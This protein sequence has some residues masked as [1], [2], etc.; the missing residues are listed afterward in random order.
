[1]GP[2]FY[3]KKFVKS[4]LPNLSDDL[5]SSTKL[6][7]GLVKP[8]PKEKEIN[9]SAAYL[10]IVESPSKCEKIESYL[11]SQY[12]CIASKGHIRTID[13]L[14]AIDIKNNFEP[15]FTL[16]E[17]K[18]AHVEWMRTTINR[19]SKN[20]IIIASDDDREGE[21]IAWHICQVFELPIETTQRIIFHEVTKPALLEAVK[22]PTKINMDLV[23]AQHARQVLDIL[24]GYKIS[25]YLWKYIYNSKA[26]SLSAGRCQT[27]AL[28]LVYDN[29]KEKKDGIEMRY[30]TIGTF[31]S[32][33]LPYELNK[34]FET[35]E[36]VLLFLEKSRDYNYKLTIHNP[37]ESIRSAPKPFN[38]SRLLQVSSNVLHISPKETM[39]LCQKLYQSG[40]ITYMRTE[41]SQYSPIFVDKI[42]EY[43]SS[44]PPSI[45]SSKKTREDLGFV[46]PQNLQYGVKYVGNV[47]KIICKD[48]GAPHEA[49]RVTNVEMS[50]L[51]TDEP[52]LASMYKLI[53]KN[54]VESCMADAKYNNIKTNI[55][56]PFELL[57][58]YTIEIPVFLGWQILDKKGSD[59][60]EMTSLHMYLS[61]LSKGTK[62]IMH[63]W[64]ESTIVMKNRHSHYTE[65]SLIHKLEEL[66]IGRPSTFASIVDTI[67]DRGYVKKTDLAGEKMNCEEYKLLDNVVHSSVKERIF[68]NEKNKLV[69]QS[70]GILTIEFLLKTF[71]KMFSYEYT[72]NMELD[73]DLVSSGKEA[74]W[75]KI[76]ANCLKDIK[77]HS[78]EIRDLTKQTYKIDEMHELMFA[79]FGPVIKYT[80]KDET[81]EEKTDFLQVKKDIEIDLEKAK[82]GEYK[83]EDLIEIKNNCLG[84]YE[85]NK[86]FLKTGRYGPYV[87]WGEKRES[88]KSIKKPLNEITIEDIK[89]LIEGSQKVTENNLL[90]RLNENMSVRKGKFGPYVFYQRSDM[91]KPQ[92]L[93]ITK[94][95]QGFFN[96]EAETL[97]NWCKE[98]YNL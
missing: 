75:T 7:V 59:P 45:F 13:G 77:V 38:T 3:K 42:K 97:I 25:P 23:K 55:T 17:D 8:L 84:E 94:F 20:N 43:I 71:D 73:L 56:A 14:K 31:F 34:E 1:M 30:K 46:E 90:R 37:K 88:I 19:F 65:A 92:F 67:V 47:D 91:K 5:R 68:G 89:A 44:H 32:K 60:N 70:V 26:N 79:P 83:T 98:T 2:K 51:Q 22:S 6:V 40:Y 52:R 21:A 28:R 11:G 41:S 29:E 50:S 58:E 49:I 78:K 69:I 18:K 27:P 35:N 10:V 87:E 24:V 57:Y 86:L 82:R 61:S 63:E 12:C 74:D 76:C 4:G 33:H 36:Q 66:G 80:Y 39:G 9:G 62:P 15:I 64:I 93:N 16:L 54:T 81:N 72:K 96:C 95:N 85:N 48:T 53:W